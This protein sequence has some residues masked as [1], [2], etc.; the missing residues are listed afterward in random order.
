MTELDKIVQDIDKL[1]T[2]QKNTL[3]AVRVI[4]EPYSDEVNIFFE[5]HKIGFATTS[6]QVGRLS[7]SYRKKL[8][9]IKQELHQR[10]KLTV[11]TN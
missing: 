2:K 4:Y 3:Y 6:E 7:G 5:Y 8:D 9:A 1:F 10:T 11:T